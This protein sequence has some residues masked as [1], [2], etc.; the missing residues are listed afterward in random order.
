MENQSLVLTLDIGTQS[1]RT[2]IFN[3][4]GET[5][6]IEKETY[7]EPYFS[8]EPGY[9]EQNPHYYWDKICSVTTK[10][11]QKNKELVPFIKAC[12]LSCFRDTAVLLDEQYR[13]VRPSILWCDQRM[14]KCRQPLSLFRR[15]LFRIAGMSEAADM[16]RKRTVMNWLNEN[17]PETIQKTKHYVNISTYLNYLLTGQ[18]K[19]SPSNYTGHYPIDMKKGKW[20]KRHS[21]KYPIFG[22][23]LEWLPELVK[24]GE[25]IGTITETCSQQT[26][27]PV[28]I[29]MIANGTDKGSETIGTGCIYKDMSSI[30][31]GTASSI[32]VSNKRYINPEP[33]LPAYPA[34]IPH[35]YN[36]EVQVYRGYWMMTWFKKEFA[37]KEKEEAIQQNKT[38]EQVLDEKIKDIPPGSQ[39]L[40]LQPY[41]GPGLRRPEAKGAMIG[42]ADYHTHLHI[43]RAIIEGIA[44]ALKEGLEGIEKRQHKKVKALRVSGGG[45][46]SDIVCQITADVFNRPVSRVQT[47]ET[48]SLG[49]AIAAF[50]AIKE[51]STYEDAIS[52]MVHPTKTFMP[53]QD[54]AQQYEFL[55]KNVYL[56]MYPRL[57]K[58][59]KKVRKYNE[60]FNRHISLS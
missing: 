21:L 11:T 19:D 32:E 2:M 4:K 47:Y 6:A 8:L 16:N 44:F 36:M 26:G 39:G 40:V 13:P 30:S 46:Q 17:E 58:L 57:K 50:V 45:S 5:L 23:P 18:L 34:C 49:A 1:I 37:D 10:I 20:F 27:L 25:T 59:N 55:Y 15:I 51:F 54:A 56:K 53:D 22:I 7:E 24:A 33:F 31:Y 41:W 60:T 43:Y 52:S 12:V 28:G 48:S 14:A 9:C 29:P 42:F 38:I 3:A 35:L